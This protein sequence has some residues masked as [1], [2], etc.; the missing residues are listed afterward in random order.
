MAYLPQPYAERDHSPTATAL[1]SSLPPASQPV[2]PSSPIASTS[3]SSPPTP[4]QEAPPRASSTRV[5]SPQ[6]TRLPIA[7]HQ[8]P[9]T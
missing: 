2:P 8:S 6:T 5:A 3:R 4:L 9:V 7:S 1:T